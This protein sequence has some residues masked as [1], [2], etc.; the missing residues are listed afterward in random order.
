M[1]LYPLQISFYQLISPSH[2]FYSPLVVTPYCAA[3][4]RLPFISFEEEAD[5]LTQQVSAPD[6]SCLIL[7]ELLTTSPCRCWMRSGSTLLRKSQTPHAVHC[8][9]AIRV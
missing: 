1:M 2:V 7:L 8:P 6:F 4:S 9:P 3:V 5:S